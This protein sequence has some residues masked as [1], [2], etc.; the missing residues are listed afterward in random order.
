LVGEFP[1]AEYVCG[2]RAGERVRLRSDIV[3]KDHRGKPTGAIY[4]RGEIWD[5]LRG[6]AEPPIVVW[7]RMLNGRPHTWSDNDDFWRQ[8]ERVDE[9]TTVTHDRPHPHRGQ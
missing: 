5:V 6:S 4:R 9:H 1:I 7:L 8:F 3:V 2:I